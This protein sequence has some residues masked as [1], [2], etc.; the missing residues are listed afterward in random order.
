MPAPPWAGDALA[1]GLQLGMQRRSLDIQQKQMEIAMQQWMKEQERLQRLDQFNLLK[2]SYDTTQDSIRN[3]QAQQRIDLYGRTED[4]LGWQ[5]QAEFQ[6][7]QAG[8]A[9]AFGTVNDMLS[10][11][12]L[13][14][15]QSYAPPASSAPSLFPQ[16]AP[17]P[18]SRYMPGPSPAG[19]GAP[20]FGPTENPYMPE[21]L[22]QRAQGAAGAPS[23][24]RSVPAQAEPGAAPG[25]AGARPAAPAAPA[26]PQAPGQAKTASKSEDELQRLESQRTG[27]EKQLAAVDNALRVPGIT[28]QA[29]AEL[30]QRRTQIEQGELDAKQAIDAT[31]KT[32]AEKEKSLGS[33]FT[34]Y[35]DTGAPIYDDGEPLTVAT[36]SG[37]QGELRDIQENEALVGKALKTIESNPGAFTA[38]G[39]LGET[40]EAVRAAIDPEGKPIFENMIDARSEV[41]LIETRLMKLVGGPLAKGVLS[42][43][44]RE[45]IQG[46]MSDFRSWVSNPTKAKKNFQHIGEIIRRAEPIKALQAKGIPIRSVDY[47]S[48][49][50]AVNRKFITEKQAH[51]II[52]EFGNPKEQIKEIE[53]LIEEKKYRAALS[54]LTAL[55]SLDPAGK[56]R[57]SLK[58]AI[59]DASD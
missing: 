6:S 11:A 57:E 53:G 15:L 45:I 13:P 5:A 31:K 22:Q 1:K 25:S 32:I 27:F 23:S 30:L 49:S 58:K 54:I 34:G 16:D 36:R 59:Q 28:S 9:D 7:S 20:G 41:G 39:K 18:D 51:G 8:A 56:T 38:R 26:A 10:G 43:Q 21:A 33:Y 19:G 14:G 17:A 3:Q 47:S 2:F 40:A 44:D 46:L 35:D 48:L 29:K 50:D 37:L 52:A 24:P 55:P 12:G 42:N 4:R